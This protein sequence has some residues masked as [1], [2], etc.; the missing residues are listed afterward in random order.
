MGSSG[1]HE[2]QNRFWANR[3]LLL[4]YQLSKNLDRTEYLLT[5][6]ITPNLYPRRIETDS[7]EAFRSFFALM[8]LQE[9][10]VEPIELTL[11]P[12]YYHHTK[13]IPQFLH[14]KE[15]ESHLHLE[16][17]MKS[18]RQ[19]FSGL[20]EPCGIGD[21]VFVE[22]KPS[23]AE[24]DY[25]IAPQFIR[26]HLE[27]NQKLLSEKLHT[28]L[29]HYARGELVHQ[30][31]YF[32]VNF[33][34]HLMRAFL[35]KLQFRQGRQVH[36]TIGGLDH[37]EFL[38]IFADQFPEEYEL[39][40]LGKYD[41][42]FWEHLLYSEQ[43]GKLKILDLKTAMVDEYVE[44]Q[45]IGLDH[46]CTQTRLRFTLP[47]AKLTQ[48]ALKEANTSI[49]VIE[50]AKAE[51]NYFFTYLNRDYQ[52]PIVLNRN[53]K[54]GEL[55]YLLAK[56]GYAE[57]KRF[58]KVFDYIQSDHRFKLFAHSSYAQ[59]PILARNNHGSIIPAKEVQI[60]LLDDVI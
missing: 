25:L 4:L 18:L 45:F 15:Q 17:V 55:I 37:D 9:F 58:R 43:Q 12:T 34:D 35:Q 53:H 31:S 40:S 13:A 8:H 42:P 3:R 1:N 52:R 20:L 54:S 27:L 10:G 57:F 33:M 56:D 50:V 19:P 39:W 49:S 47:R 21:L 32:G 5:D 46:I 29:L 30:R 11:D 41:L 2:N 16:T 6:L 36:V 22:E 14:P 48:K 26:T 24:W 60:M 28:Y 44:T 38:K 59:Q 23:D 7:W 51:G